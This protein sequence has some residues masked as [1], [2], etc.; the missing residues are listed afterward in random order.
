[1]NKGR[2]GYLELSLK[3]FAKILLT[4]SKTTKTF[5]MAIQAC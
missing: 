2:L 1:M 4:F 5:S 3:C